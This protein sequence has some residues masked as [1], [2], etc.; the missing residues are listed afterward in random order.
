MNDASYISRKMRDSKLFEA[1][2]MVKIIPTKEHHNVSLRCHAW[3]EAAENLVR[4]KN[5][6]KYLLA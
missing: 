4:I 2:S 3:N 6:K 5:N 1:V